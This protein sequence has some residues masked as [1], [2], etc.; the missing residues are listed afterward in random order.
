MKFFKKFFSNIGY[1]AKM[2]SLMW[3]CDKSYLFYVLIDIAVYSSVPFTSMF[4]VQR[5]IQMLEENA[6]FK[7][8]FMVVTGYLIAYLAL[9]CLH[10]YLNY[11]RDL[12]GNVIE[13][14]L[15][16]I[17]FEKTLNID[18]EMLLDKEIQEKKEL[19]L[20][21]VSGGRFSKIVTTFHNFVSNI[22]ILFG[23]IIVL[24]QV[25]VWILIVSLF[26]VAMNTAA[27]M[28][29]NKFTRAINVNI[30]PLVR[31]V[32][33][34]M[35]IGSSFSFIKEI[36]T[37]G[38]KKELANRY[39][40]LQG[41]IYKGL[42][43]TIHLS[44]MG[45]II[46]HVSYFLLNMV[47]Y[48]F[49]G[50]RVLA[51]HNLSIAS[52][53]MFLN[54]GLNFNSAMS[55][56][57][58]TFANMSANGQYLQDYFDFIS[59]KGME[60]KRDG[61]PLLLPENLE[62]SFVF[63]NVS[64]RYPQQENYALRNVSVKIGQHEKIAIVG[65]NGAGKTTLV[66]LLMRLMEPTEGRILLNGVDIRDYDENEYRKL[67]STVFQDFKLFSFTIEDN[68]AALTAGDTSFVETAIKRAG[69]DAKLS[70]LKKGVG[71]Y[72]D[73]LYD[74]EGV[75]LSGGESQRLAIARALYKNAP[76][77]ILDEPTAALDPR[78][79]NEIYT[80]F[81]EITEGKTT[82]YITHRLASTHFC[83]RI[84]VMKNG[85]VEEVGNHYELMDRNGYYAELYQMQAQYYVESEQKDE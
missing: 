67:F 47:S 4:L 74:N 27:T 58:S 66:M 46:S 76:V 30:N 13:L 3:R 85:G 14:K 17:I 61:E 64:Y 65:E 15:Y 34:F 43:K 11:K 28:Y 19:A 56:I 62:C 20:N 57:V 73:K 25:D 79:E 52:F 82:F 37:Y 42:D 80:K 84:I 35:D 54:A 23:I 71:T 16:K 44:L 10:N 1:T 7:S 60:D 32:E 26:I 45:Y 55:T 49:L 9:N 41:E 29:R 5:S 78:I 75:V 63:E 6:E 68:V 39:S 77:Y 2:L 24:S 21:V 70:T 48:G 81:R 22:V 50:F 69:L 83:D 59:L 18:Y 53:S 8:F 72:I 40:D 38:M 36:K 33:Y 12:H 31:R 51:K